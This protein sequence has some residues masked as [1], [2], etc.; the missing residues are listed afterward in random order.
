M[1]VMVLTFRYNF[2]RFQSI[3]PSNLWSDWNQSHFECFLYLKSKIWLQC[4]LIDWQFLL[5]MP[6]HTQKSRSE[7]KILWALSRTLR[8]LEI[9]EQ[10]FWKI[11]LESHLLL[12]L[13]IKRFFYMC[14]C[15]CKKALINWKKEKKTE[16]K[17]C[18]SGLIY[19]SNT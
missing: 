15:I 9:Q 5:C 6:L 14:I 3:F 16:L 12:A 11:P 1:I 17:M 10:I 2:D 8:A 18:N 4:S 7:S 19:F 13:K